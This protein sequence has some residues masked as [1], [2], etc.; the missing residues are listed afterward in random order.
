MVLADH[1]PVRQRRHDNGCNGHDREDLAVAPHQ[2]H[3]VLADMANQH[4]A[5]GKVA[6]AMPFSRSGPGGADF[7]RPLPVS[8]SAACRGR[9]DPSITGLVHYRSGQ[10]GVSFKPDRAV[11]PARRN[12]SRISKSAAALL[13]SGG[14][15]RNTIY[16]G[17]SLPPVTGG[18]F[19]S[20]DHIAGLIR[21]GFDAKA[22]YGAS[23][24]GHSQFPV[25]VARLGTQFQP[26]DIMVLGE[27]HSFA[28]ASAIP[29]RKVMHNQNPYM[30][31]YGIASVAEL[32]AYPLAHILVSSDF[33]AAC[34]RQMGVTKSIHRIRPALPDYFAPKPKKLQIAYAPGKREMEAN[35]LKGYFR[36][37]VPD[38]AHVPW[39]ALSGLTRQAC[40]AAMAESAVYAA[41]PL[42]ESLGL[43]SLEAMA[44]G[45]HVVGYT[46]HGGTE[47]ATPEN[48]DWIV[49]GDHAAFAAALG[50]ACRQFE[51][52]A[53]SPKIE[54]GRLT[55]ARFNQTGFDNE[56]AA[57]WTSIL[58]DKAGLYRLYGLASWSWARSACPTPGLR[59][60]PA[61]PHPA[62]AH[63][64]P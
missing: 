58:G 44:S 22:F 37:V 35:F 33:G 14:M 36:A 38:Y 13:G 19:V 27:N 21:M 28:A 48:G 1:Q 63:N 25:P 30:T 40:A 50:A 34:L 20:L 57:A 41:L 24:H 32:N 45:C 23:D 4:A 10:R 3:R 8:C 17:F 62:A 59:V 29:A 2:Q 26:D 64:A 31:F 61:A 7:P 53:A 60:P 6:S 9:S 47:Y 51:L 43:M 5:F 52:G 15:A 11:F 55:A 49:D 56:L 42:L 46:G 16:Y 18:D 39:I 54:A 12:A